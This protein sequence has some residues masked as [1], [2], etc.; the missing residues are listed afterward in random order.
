M[1][2]E[3]WQSLGTDA[4]T[5]LYALGITFY[6]LLTGRLPFRGGIVGLMHQH[7]GSPVPDP[8]ERVPDIP[9]EWHQIVQI[10]TAKDPTLRFP[11]ASALVA[12]LDRAIQDL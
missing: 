7:T 3:L 4:R 10:L 12:A 6:Q 8:R 2:P 1:A 11:S 9:E 5:D